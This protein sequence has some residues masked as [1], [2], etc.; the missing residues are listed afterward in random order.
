MEKHV[1]ENP[2]EYMDHCPNCSS[3]NIEYRA[4][5]SDKDEANKRWPTWVCED[6]GWEW[7]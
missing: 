7:D 2:T 4:Y 5:P 3:N 6:C 1:E